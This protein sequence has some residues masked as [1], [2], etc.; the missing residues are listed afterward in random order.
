MLPMNTLHRLPL[1]QCR[2]LYSGMDV[3]LRQ[4]LRSLLEEKV[5]KY[6]LPDLLFPSFSASR[7]FRTKVGAGDY[8]YSAAALLEPPHKDI[9]PTAAALD[10]ADCLTVLVFHLFNVQV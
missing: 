7:G 2:Q 6:G 3:N 4:D 1:V 8:V 10:V 9:T 5:E